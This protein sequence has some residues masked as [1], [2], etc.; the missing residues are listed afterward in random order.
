M[1]VELNVAQRYNC[2]TLNLVFQR[3]LNRPIPLELAV[4]LVLPAYCLYDE[5]NSKFER[6]F[7]AMQLVRLH[8]FGNWQR[9]QWNCEDIER[10]DRSRWPTLPSV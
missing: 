10:S 5:D 6:E 7:I 4:V 1:P 2:V 3:I 8:A 9:E